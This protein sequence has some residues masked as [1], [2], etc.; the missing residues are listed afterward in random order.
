MVPPERPC[1]CVVTEVEVAL[2]PLEMMDCVCASRDEGV[3]DVAVLLVTDSGLIGRDDREPD[4]DSPLPPPIGSPPGAGVV[5]ASL[6]NALGSR[7]RNWYI[8]FWLSRSR[9]SYV[10]SWKN[11]CAS[12][13][14]PRRRARLRS[15]VLIMKQILSTASAP[16]NVSGYASPSLTRSERGM[17][18]RNASATLERS[19][20]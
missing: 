4:D 1:A 19:A 6:V 9:W 7:A 18:A 15:V 14:R 11:F 3:R 20:A 8:S 2:D 16:S 10:T 13:A 12:S 17:R 5:S